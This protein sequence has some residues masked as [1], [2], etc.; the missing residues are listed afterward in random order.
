MSSPKIKPMNKDPSYINTT[1]NCVNPTP[2]AY[3]DP[4]SVETDTWVM[5]STKLVFQT[6]NAV[7]P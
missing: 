7:I 5:L 2:N 1:T 3:L 4:L 6:Y